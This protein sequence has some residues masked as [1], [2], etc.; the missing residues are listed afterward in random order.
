[1]SYMAL[2]RKWRPATFDEVR[3]QDA[4]VRTLKNQIIFRFFVNFFQ[5]IP[6]LRFKCY[7]LGIT[8]FIICKKK[9]TNF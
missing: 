4:I 5:N 7:S 9:K 2:Y 3:G 6:C 1:M 8:F